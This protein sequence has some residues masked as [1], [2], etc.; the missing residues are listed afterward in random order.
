MSYRLLENSRPL[1]CKRDGLLCL[2]RS[3]LNES[4]LAGLRG[5]EEGDGRLT[6]GTKVR[7]L[8]VLSRVSQ[9]HVDGKFIFS[10]SDS[11]PLPLASGGTRPSLQVSSGG[12]STPPQLHPCLWIQ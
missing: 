4:Q 10:R 9:G 1:L 11:F 8:A 5:P 2:I 7:A 3:P 12:D 6:V